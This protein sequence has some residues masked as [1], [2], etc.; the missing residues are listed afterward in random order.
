MNKTLEQIRAALPAHIMLTPGVHIYRHGDEWL[1]GD[2]EWC[3]VHHENIGR[4]INIT[5]QPR[6]RR[7]IPPYILDNQAWYLYAQTQL[8]QQTGETLAL[9]VARLFPESFTVFGERI[10]VRNDAGTEATRALV[11]AELEAQERRKKAKGKA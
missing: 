7:E 11:R 4:I 1:D 2:L 5:F 9:Y 8:G 3:G 6:V 10:A